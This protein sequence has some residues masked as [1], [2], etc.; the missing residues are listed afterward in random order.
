MKIA[1][2]GKG[3]T[4]KTSL[5][6]ALAKSFVDAGGEVLAIDADPTSN[7]AIALGHPH[8]EEGVPL[9]KIKELIAERTGTDTSV[10]YGKF[11]KLNP[12]VEDIP[13]TYRLS[14]SG[15]DFIVLG[16]VHVAAGGCYC[17]ENVFL[18]SLIS[19]LVL[20]RDEVVILDMEA[21]IEHLGRG[22]VRGIDVLIVLVEP[23]RRS[24]EATKTIFDLAAKLGIGRVGLVA[25]KIASERQRK[26]IEDSVDAME[27]LGF[28]SLNE[29]LQETDITGEAVFSNNP[30]FM[31]EVNRIRERIEN[32]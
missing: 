31:E 17:P 25:N 32:P 4:G 10:S 20:E 12:H 7:L 1:V 16:A 27:L 2:S 30:L 18:Q 5:V 28:L 15:V 14:A 11:F 13:D 8:P 3:G 24:I 21:G 29:R 9:I 26:F 6:A 19:H 23:T 22:T